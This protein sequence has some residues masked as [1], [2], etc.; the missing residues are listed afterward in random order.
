MVSSVTGPPTYILHITR[1]MTRH[2]P[3]SRARLSQ[4]KHGK[5]QCVL[6]PRLQRTQTSCATQ[7]SVA[8]LN[9]VTSMPNSTVHGRGSWRSDTNLNGMPAAWTD[10]RVLKDPQ[11]NNADV[12]VF[13][14]TQSSLQDLPRPCEM[15]SQLRALGYTV[16]TTIP[17]ATVEK[18]V[19]HNGRLEVP[20]HRHPQLEYVLKFVYYQCVRAFRRAPRR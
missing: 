15:Y 10:G 19:R 12:V 11:A 9:G 2:S 1:G 4:P 7:L 16:S 20:A 14:E 17:R 3:P 6:S 18:Q 8:S 5:M 13:I